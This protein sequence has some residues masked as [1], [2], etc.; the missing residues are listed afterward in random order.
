LE[1]ATDLPALQRAIEACRDGL[2]IDHLVY[3]WVGATGDNYGVYTYSAAWVDHYIAQDYLRIDPVIQGCYRHFHPLDWKQLDWSAKAAREFLREAIDFGV[4]NQ[5]YSVPIR[6]PNGQ[7]AL[8]S[9]SHSCGDPEWAAFTGANRRSLILLAHAFHQ[10]ALEL[11]P[12]R[13]APQGQALSPREV[14][15]LTLLAVGYGR[16]QVAQTLNIFE[17]TLRAYIES[18]RFKLGA[19]NTLH[20]VA[21][22]LSRGA[23]V[24]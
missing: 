16:A 3:H 20:A 14:D 1:T 2:R 15:A 6:G 22:A 13:S 9:A 19:S 7:F 11:E 4:G 5:G 12:K 23:I 21:C 10:K 17:H 18:A 24:I 8:F